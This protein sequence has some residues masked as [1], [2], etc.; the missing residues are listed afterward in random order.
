MVFRLVVLFLVILSFLGWLSFFKASFFKTSLLKNRFL[1]DDFV[2]VQSLQESTPWLCFGLCFSDSRWRLNFAPHTWGLMQ[3]IEQL[4]SQLA[5]IAFGVGQRPNQSA[6]TFYNDFKLTG[7]KTLF[8][9]NFFSWRSLATIQHTKSRNFNYKKKSRE[10]GPD[11]CTGQ[12]VQN[13]TVKRRPQGGA[14]LN[15]AF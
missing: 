12:S 1:K 11:C 4:S 9:Q 13:I 7:S 2:F 14:P 6:H 5:R 10:F 8:S 15:V 3:L